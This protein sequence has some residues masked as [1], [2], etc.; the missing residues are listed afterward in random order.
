MKES[1]AITNPVLLLILVIVTLA[2]LAIGVNFYVNRTIE[3]SKKIR[4]EA[5]IIAEKGMQLALEKINQDPNWNGAFD[6]HRYKRG[7]FFVFIHNS[8]DSLVADS[9]VMVIKS[10]GII[11]NSISDTL[12]TMLRVSQGKVSHPIRTNW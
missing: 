5:K 1:G 2:G 9:K 8:S 12:M 4:V 7:E 11:K 10:I 3:E 6:D